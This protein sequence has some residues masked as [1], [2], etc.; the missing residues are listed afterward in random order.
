MVSIAGIFMVGSIEIAAML[1]GNDGTTLIPVVAAICILAGYK[2]PDLIG[3]VK[4]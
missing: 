3:V 2:L 4:K 1:T